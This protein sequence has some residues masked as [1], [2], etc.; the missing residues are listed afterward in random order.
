MSFRFVTTVLTLGLIVPVFAMSDI[1]DDVARV[2]HSNQVFQEIMHSPDNAIPT[3]VLHNAH[4]I[5]IVPGEKSAALGIGGIYGKGVATC[6]DDGAWSAPMFI[7][8]SGASLGVQLGGEST[9]V[10]MVFRTRQ[11][12]ESL[13]TDKVKIGADVSAAAG[14]VGRDA[15]ASTDAAEI[16]TYARGRGAFA[17]VSLDGGMVQADGSADTA[18]YADATW[19][20]ILSGTVASP[21]STHALLATLDTYSASNKY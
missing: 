5:A 7:Q 19:K 9:D 18:M 13:L 1:S 6:R 3:E 2:D 21:D 4:C 8:I 16:L 15:G 14:P 11:G 20:A 10:I 17:G 12:L